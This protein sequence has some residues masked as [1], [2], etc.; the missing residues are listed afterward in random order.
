MAI[1]RFQFALPYFTNMPSDVVTNDWHMS[2]PLGSPADGDF[3][4]ARDRLVTFYDEVY[5]IGA[6]DDLMAPWMLPAAA[7]LKVY[8]IQD[9]IPRAP[10]Y[11]SAAPLA[12]SRAASAVTAL[13]TAICLSFQGDPLSGVPQAR[14]RGRV[15]LGGFAGVVAAGDDNQFP[16]VDPIIVTGIADAASTLA[17]GLTT[18]GWVWVV[19]SRVNLSGAPVTNGWV[20]NALD[21]QRRREVGATSRVVFP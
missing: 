15:F 10:V 14:R 12:D 9:P 20:D 4:N 6:G 3:E 16:V 5:A 7:T 1:Y 18:D 19:Y 13:E 17:G 8:N 2:W 21:T 11:L